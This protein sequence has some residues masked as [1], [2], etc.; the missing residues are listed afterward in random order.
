V[1]RLMNMDERKRPY[2]SMI[3]IKKPTDL[4]MEAYYMKKRR[5]EDPMAQFT[6]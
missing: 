3:E 4:E 1:D 6:S 2:N 5:D